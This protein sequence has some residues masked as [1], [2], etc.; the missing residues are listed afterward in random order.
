M[1]YLKNYK[2]E[3]NDKD[4]KDELIETSKFSRVRSDGRIG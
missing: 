3:I 1:D 2:S 4:S